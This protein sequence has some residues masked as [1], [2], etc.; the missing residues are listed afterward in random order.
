MRWLSKRRKKWKFKRQ[1]RQ[2]TQKCSK[3]ED[4]EYIPTDAIIDEFEH[5]QYANVIVKIVYLQIQK[6]HSFITSINNKAITSQC[7]NNC[8]NDLRGILKRTSQSKIQLHST[9][10]S[11]V[12]KWYRWYE[13]KSLTKLGRQHCNTM[14]WHSF[15]TLFA[16]KTVF[17]LCESVV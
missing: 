6:S 15:M 10:L 8:T 11:T 13:N 1:G 14:L 5:L 4:Y 3:N 9:R 17:S 16:N 2:T 7:Y 12:E